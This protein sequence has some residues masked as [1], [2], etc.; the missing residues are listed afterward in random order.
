MRGRSSSWRDTELSWV[1]EW[2]PVVVRVREPR[3]DHSRS[4]ADRAAGRD[5]ARAASS[6]ISPTKA[7][8]P[9]TPQQVRGC[10]GR[11]WRGSSG[12]RALGGWG[13]AHGPP[14][15]PRAAPTPTRA[16][17]LRS[18]WGDVGEVASKSPSRV[19]L[20]WCATA[21]DD[22][23]ERLEDVAPVRPTH[24]DGRMVT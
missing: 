3:P 6:A 5:L 12:A 19:I 20:A 1:V 4:A 16:P 8:A 2:S 22:G 15:P 17:L 11:R 10:A 7:A 21:T 24:D 23:L 9:S 18:S 14:A 13:E